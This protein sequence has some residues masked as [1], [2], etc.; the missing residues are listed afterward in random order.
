M[1]DSAKCKYRFFIVYDFY[2]FSVKLYIEVKNKR[3]DYYETIQKQN[4][5]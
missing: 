1:H 3:I 4:Y 2:F 5:P